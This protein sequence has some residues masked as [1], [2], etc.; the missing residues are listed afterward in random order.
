MLH[1]LRYVTSFIDGRVRLRHPALRQ[2]HVVAEIQPRLLR[3]NGIQSAEFNERSGSLLLYYDTAILSRDELIRQALPWADYLD[4]CLKGHPATP[5]SGGGVGEHKP[6][7][8]LC[9][10]ICWRKAV[11]RGML[12]SLAVTAGSLAL[13]SKKGHTVAGICFL[14]FAGVHVW[15]YRRSL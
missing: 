2:R 6:A 1:V 9:G 10:N 12:A 8:P 4:A 3:I 7:F 5:P 13:G 15:R 14:A 11:N